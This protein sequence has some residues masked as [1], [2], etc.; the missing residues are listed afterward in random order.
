MKALQFN[1]ESGSTLTLLRWALLKQHDS[2]LEFVKFLVSECGV[3]LQDDVSVSQGQPYQ[4]ILGSGI[5]C[6]SFFAER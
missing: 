3:K 4:H 2:S 5:H 6:E 1:N